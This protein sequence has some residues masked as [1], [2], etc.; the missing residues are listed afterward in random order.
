MFEKVNPCHP[1]KESFPEKVNTFHPFLL[2]LHRIKAKY[3]GRSME[4]R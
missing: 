4:R 3:Y 1:D 2:S